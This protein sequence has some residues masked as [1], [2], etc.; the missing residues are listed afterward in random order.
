MSNFCCTIPWILVQSS[1]YYQKFEVV[2][3][4]GGGMVVVGGGM[5][6]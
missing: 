1:E 2:E 3:V 5:A 4:G 6:V